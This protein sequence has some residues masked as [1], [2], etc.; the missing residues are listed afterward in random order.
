MAD[1]AAARRHDLAYLTPAAWR[2]HVAGLEDTVLDWA[3]FGRPAIFRRRLC[4]DPAG[5]VPLGLPLPPG[6]G[7]KRLALSC[8]PDA[9]R[10]VAPPPLLRDARAAAPEAW[11]T[12]IDALLS[13]EPAWRCF[14]SLAW[15]HLTGL[16]YLT[17]TSDLD[18]LIPCP[19]Q[20]DAARLTTALAEIAVEAPMRLDAELLSPAGAGVQW[21]EWMSDAPDLLVKTAEATT[22]VP[23]EG[24]F[25]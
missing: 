14:G 8:P 6:M 9:I 16:P 15:Q 5:A 18:L 11:Q 22:L 7:R 1:P 24:V 21:R 3:D 12:V 25:P 2:D 4:G 20:A 13:R 19:T 23:R 10:W 17:A